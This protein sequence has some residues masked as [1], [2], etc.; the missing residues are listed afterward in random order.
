MW[1]DPIIEEVRQA[2][3]DYVASLNY[4]LEAIA[5]D[6]RAKGQASGHPVVTL[7]PKPPKPPMTLTLSG[8]DA[9][10][11]ANADEASSQIHKT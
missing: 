3:E 8:Q 6:L 11:L 4:D 5:R 2:R 9:P 1:H 10:A 7:P